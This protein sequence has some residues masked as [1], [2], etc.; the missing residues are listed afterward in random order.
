MNNSDHTQP[1]QT[2]TYIA[3]LK[4]QFERIDQIIESGG[5]VKL[6]NF[7]EYAWRKLHID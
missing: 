3:Q 2:D 1:G 6:G 5:T 7:A 4:E